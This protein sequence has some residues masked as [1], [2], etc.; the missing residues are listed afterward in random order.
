MIFNHNI[1]RHILQDHFAEEIEAG[2]KNTIRHIDIDELD[3]DFSDD[4]ETLRLASIEDID[5]DTGDFEVDETADGTLEISGNLIVVAAVV[6]IDEDGLICDEET[7]LT[8][9]YFFRFQANPKGACGKPYTDLY[10]E[11]L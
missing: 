10:M 3:V 11:S 5:T 9:D 8:L 6:P 1:I 2:V 7:E 4:A